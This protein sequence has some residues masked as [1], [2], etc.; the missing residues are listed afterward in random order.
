MVDPKPCATLDFTFSEAHLLR[1]LLMLAYKQTESKS[2]EEKFCLKIVSQIDA[3]INERVHGV[4]R[5]M[6]DAVK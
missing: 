3:M 4:A 5:V 6:H 1:D 2:R